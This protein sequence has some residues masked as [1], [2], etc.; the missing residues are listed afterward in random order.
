MDENVVSLISVHRPRRRG[1]FTE[2]DLTPLKRVMPHL[3]RALRLHDNLQRAKTAVATLSC[4]STGVINLAASGKVLSFNES[5]R[6]MLEQRDGL[7]VDGH[8]NLN[9]SSVRSPFFRA[10]VA[11]AAATGEG[12]GRHPGSVVSIHRPSGKRPYTVVVGPT[13]CDFLAFGSV[14]AAAIAFVTDPESIATTDNDFLG[15]FYG[16]TKAESRLVNLMEAGRSLKEAAELNHVSYETVRSQLR[17]IFSKTG[18]RRQAELIRL[19]S[20]AKA[21]P[22]H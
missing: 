12:R 7:Q 5:A 17:T 13:H 11:E 21:T 10:L 16:L 9:T 1:Q 8:G 20:R 19:L 6:A 22:N 2:Q 18:V 15:Q 3:Q 14:K 4:F